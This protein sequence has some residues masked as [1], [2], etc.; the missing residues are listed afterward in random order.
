MSRPICTD[1][2]VLRRRFLKKVQIVGQHWLW[3]GAKIPANGYGRFII[4]GKEVTA[5]RA[6][7]ILFKGPIP[8]KVLILHKHEGM[9]LCV[10]PDC[11]KSGDQFQNAKDFTGSGGDYWTKLNAEKAA[12]IRASKASPQELAKMYNVS[13]RSVHN[14]LKGITWREAE[15]HK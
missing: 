8:D 14:V 7:W 3:L 5:H 10:N 15:D 6:A 1:F 9:K 12:E 4:A 11:L 2:R 13:I